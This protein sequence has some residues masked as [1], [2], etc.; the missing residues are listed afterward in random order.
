M[1][2]F[3]FSLFGQPG[4]SGSL[5][6]HHYHNAQTTNSRMLGW[7]S[8]SESR[9]LRTGSLTWHLAK[10]PFIYLSLS[11]PPSPTQPLK[12]AALPSCATLWPPPASVPACVLVLWL[13]KEVLVYNCAVREEAGEP[14]GEPSVKPLTRPFNLQAAGCEAAVLTAA[15]P[16]HPKQKKNCVCSVVALFSLFCR[17]LSHTDLKHW[18]PLTK[19]P[20]YSIFISVFFLSGRSVSASLSDVC[21]AWCSAVSQCW[22]HNASFHPSNHEDLLWADDSK[23]QVVCQFRVLVLRSVRP[24]FVK[25][26]SRR[27]QHLPSNKWNG[28]DLSRCFLPEVTMIPHIHPNTAVIFVIFMYYMGDRGNW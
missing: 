24:M 6:A 22:V 10:H 26:I 14:W 11:L 7:Y 9:S 20:A 3:L 2:Y 1:K 25:R 13:C 16:R 19:Q 27:R 4:C 28:L 17:P 23:D 5:L 8:G 18:Y 21:P 12:E 15:T